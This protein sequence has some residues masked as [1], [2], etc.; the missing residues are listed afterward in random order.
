M[1][2]HHSGSNFLNSKLLE[3]M[4]SSHG[5][6]VRFGSLADIAALPS[7]VRYTPKNR[8]SPAWLGC[9]QRAAG[10]ADAPDDDRSDQGEYLKDRP[11]LRPANEQI[12]QDENQ[13]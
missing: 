5:L 9:A 1:N 12:G 8:H 13:H 2:S 6:D 4:S 3:L 7:H 10:A 11:T